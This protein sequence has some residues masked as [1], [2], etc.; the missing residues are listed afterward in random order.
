MWKSEVGSYSKCA[1]D[2]GKS[3]QETFPAKK[4]PPLLIGYQIESKQLI[5]RWCQNS[6]IFAGFLH[7][8]SFTTQET[9]D[10][11]IQKIQI[12]LFRKMFYYIVGTNKSL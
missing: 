4:S 7:W 8:D 10:Q 9:S 1:D 11:G 2:T 3:K 5:G 6:N 12:M